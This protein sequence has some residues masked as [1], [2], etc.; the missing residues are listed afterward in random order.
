MNDMGH[1]HEILL[2]DYAIEDLRSELEAQRRSAA[3]AG[4]F[5][6]GV[7]MIV[8]FFIGWCL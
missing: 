6:M 3:L 1:L 8:G 2:R 7:G 4:C 5:M